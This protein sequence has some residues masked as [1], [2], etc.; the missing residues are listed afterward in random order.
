MC[1]FTTQE[2]LEPELQD[3]TSKIQLS[4]ENVSYDSLNIFFKY[5]S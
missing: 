3:C 1:L 2:E 5:D 4:T